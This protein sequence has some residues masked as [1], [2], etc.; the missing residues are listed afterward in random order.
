MRATSVLNWHMVV[1]NC[2]E[3]ESGRQS[4]KLNCFFNFYRFL[5]VCYLSTFWH[6]V[7]ACAE[8]ESGRISGNL[9]NFFISVT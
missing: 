9:G 5:V 3:V 2:A 1:V 8:V 6:M 7:E 4:R